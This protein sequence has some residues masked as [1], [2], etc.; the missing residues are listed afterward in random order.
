MKMN[1]S[2]AV[3]GAEAKVYCKELPVQGR[4][5]SRF[6]QE[7]RPVDVNVNVSVAPATEVNCHP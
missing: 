7:A 6:A 2:V 4:T 1:C 3:A 5:L